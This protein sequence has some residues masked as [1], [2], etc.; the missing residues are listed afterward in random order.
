MANN[1]TTADN[2]LTSDLMIM[3]ATNTA[4]SDV[5]ALFAS[6]WAELLGAGEFS[7]DDNFIELGGNSLLATI[8]ATRLQE[9]LGIAI[10]IQ[11]IFQLSFGQLR[12]CFIW[13]RSARPRN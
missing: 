1:H 7:A 11:D 5:K 13:R 8:L 12:C 2:P 10:D 3:N 4:T 6:V 9:E